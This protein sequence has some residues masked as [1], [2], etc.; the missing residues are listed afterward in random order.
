M[1]K[2]ITTLG[3]SCQFFNGKAHEKD[4]DAEGK[5]VVVNSKFISRNGQVRKYTGKQMFPLF[6]DDIVM[7]MSDVPNGKALA[8]CYIIEE[9]DKY[10]LNQRICAI[11]TTEFDIRFLYYQ[12]NRHPYLLAFNNGENQSNLRKG[13]ILKCPLWKPSLKIQKQIVELLDKALEKIDKAK[14]NIDKNID[15][16]NDLFQSKLNE[17]FNQKGDGWEEKKIEDLT[18]LVTKGSSPKWQGINY[19]KKPGIL[20]VTSENVGEGK[21]LMHKRKYLE[22]KFNNKQKKSILKKG[23][24]LT[25]IVGA[26]IGRTAI[27]DLEELANI[28]QAVCIMRCNESDLYN[29]Y[30]MYLLNSPYFKTILHENEVNNARANLSLTFFKNLIIPVPT[31]QKQIE[32]VNYIQ[33][34][35][36]ETTLLSNTIECKLQNIIELKKSILQKAFTGELTHTKVTA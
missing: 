15:N 9:N 18:E 14:A 32:L 8:K 30:L 29:Y 3:E 33:K 13:D 27:Y 7:V 22:E 26:S 10:S 4:I 36:K 2:E 35:H 31:L 6:E 21:L 34:F 16:A 12:L 23:D 5:F 20:F 28:N 24:V 25:N 11:R 17:I 19:V 1:S